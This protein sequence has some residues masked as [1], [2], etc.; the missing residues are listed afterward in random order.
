MTDSNSRTSPRS[1]TVIATWIF[2]ISTANCPMV[3]LP[4]APSRKASARNWSPS[5][6]SSRTNRRARQSAEA[7]AQ[8]FYAAGT[9]R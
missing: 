8:V 7:H 5:A 3:N 4:R 2:P 6:P 9:T 1:P